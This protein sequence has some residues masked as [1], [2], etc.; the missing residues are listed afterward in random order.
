MYYIYHIPGIKIG[1]STEPKRRVETQGYYDYEILEEYENITLA[2]NRELELQKQYGYKVD[3]TTYEQSYD[4]CNKGHSNGGKRTGQILKENGEW[5]KRRQSGW[6]KAK[7]KT[8]KPIIVYHYPSMEL[9][10]EYKSVS[11]ACRELNL[12]RVSV[13]RIL[14][15]SIGK[16]LKSPIQHQHHHYTFRYK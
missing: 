15:R 2:S 9:K 1:C 7:E 5:E 14:S 6:L 11:E 8:S 16:I 3:N 13:I 10:G 4:W 12:D